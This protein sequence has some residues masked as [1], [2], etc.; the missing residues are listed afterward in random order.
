MESQKSERGIDIKL[1]NFRLTFLTE[2]FENA[3]SEKE[4][5]YLNEL[6]ANQLSD[7]AEEIFRM[8]SE[9]IRSLSESENQKS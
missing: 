4:L 5:G 3:H 1:S 7:L 8:I 2:E 9:F 6:E